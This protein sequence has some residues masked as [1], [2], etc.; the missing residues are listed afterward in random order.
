MSYIRNGYPLT[1]VDGISEDYIFP[2]AEPDGKGG[3]TTGYIEDYGSI[4]DNT[5]IEVLYRHWKTDDEE[6]KDYLLKRLAERL[7][8][9]LREKPLTFDEFLE[10]TKEIDK[11]FQEENK[12]LLSR[13]GRNGNKTK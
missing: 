12:E 7:N 10:M 9:K 1:Y 4:K 6:F 5:I 11:K 8:V 3:Y 2:S 13:I